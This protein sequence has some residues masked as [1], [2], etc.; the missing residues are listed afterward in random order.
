LYVRVVYR[1]GRACV[2]SGA[3]E[4]VVHGLDR[5]VRRCQLNAARQSICCVYSACA[6]RMPLSS[7]FSCLQCKVL[8]VLMFH[9]LSQIQ[10]YYPI[11]AWHMLM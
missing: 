8:I 6:W 9:L 10:A 3:V 7:S 11:C 4:C 2:M 5:R 1:A